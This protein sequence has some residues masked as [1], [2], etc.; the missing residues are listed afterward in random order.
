MKREKPDG[1]AELWD[2]LIVI[3][4]YY[5]GYWAVFVGL[6]NLMPGV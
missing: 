2:I 4:I 1:Q 5:I 3:S 6:T